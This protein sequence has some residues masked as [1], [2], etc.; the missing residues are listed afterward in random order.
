MIIDLIFDAAALAAPPSFRNTLQQAAT[1]LQS[2]FTDNITININI[3]YNENGIG[4]GSASGGPDNGLFESYQSV[5]NFLTQDAS[6]GDNSFSALPNATTINGQSQVAV[7]NSELKL[8]GLLGANDTTTNDGSCD[9]S[10]SISSNLLLGVALHEL[11]HAMGRVPYGPEPDVFDLFRYTSDG[12]RLFST[13]IPSQAAYFSLNGGLTKWADYGINSDP[14]DFL[15]SPSSNLSPEDAFNEFY[16]SGTLQFLTP[17]DLEQLDVL[18]FHLKTPVDV[19]NFDFGGD[20]SGDVLLQS[21]SGQIVYANMLGGTFQGWIGL[22]STP[23]WT[24]EGQGKI[25]GGPDADIVIENASGTILYGNLVNGA[26]SNWVTVANAPGFNVVGVG[27]INGDG[28]ADIVV[29]NPTTGEIDYANM[30]NGAFSNWVNV[31][32]TPGW[33]VD[34][35]ADVTGDGFPD[36]IIQNSSGAIAYANMANGTFNGFVGLPGTPGWKVMGAGDI[37]RDGFADI[38]VENQS[39]GQIAYANM[40]NGVFNSWVS[41]GATPGWNVIAVEDVKGNGF[42]DIVIENQSSGQL[43]YA[44]MT[45]GTFQ[46]WVGIGSAPGYIGVTREGDG[47]AGASAAFGSFAPGAVADGAAAPA[48]SIAPQGSDGMP[49]SGGTSGAVPVPVHMAEAEAAN[50]VTQAASTIPSAFVPPLQISMLDPGP[51]VP[52]PITMVDPPITIAASFIPP[53]SPINLLDPGSHG[54]G[55]SGGIHG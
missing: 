53:Q 29:Q 49:S 52:S 6:H 43:A 51:A 15:N 30:A 31:A 18:G 3:Q 2:M 20:N 9:F 54:T 25:S 10:A 12:T 32:S 28:F 48:F 36:I 11:A 40:D 4:A 55:G 24:V 27:D 21:S 23:G 41:V 33:T 17:L 16:D 42:S 44:D 45:T 39:T 47:T 14:S 26:F 37:Q 22:A 35:V 50:V 19:D 13:A 46:G 7:W 1:M 38:V 34:A 5:Y 8:W